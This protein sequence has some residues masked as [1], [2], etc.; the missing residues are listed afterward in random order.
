M[1]SSQ[2][3]GCGGADATAVRD[4]MCTR[5]RKLGNDILAI[6]RSAIQ[7]VDELDAVYE[8][9]HQRKRQ[10][11][12]IRLTPQSSVKGKRTHTFKPP[13]QDTAPRAQP[14]PSLP[15]QPALGE[16][17]GVAGPAAPS[18][19]SPPEAAPAA[20]SGSKV[21]TSHKLSG[22]LKAA[23]AS[24]T[25]VRGAQPPANEKHQQ[26][27]DSRNCKRLIPAT[28]LRRK[29]QK[30]SNRSTPTLSDH[31]VL[32]RVSSSDSADVGK[33]GA[34]FQTVS[35]ENAII[36][37][38]QA[39]EESY[40]RILAHPQTQLSRGGE[41]AREGLLYSQLR[42][43]VSADHNID[44]PANRNEAAKAASVVHGADGATIGCNAEYTEDTAFDGA[45]LSA[46]PCVESFELPEGIEYE[47]EALC[48]P[49]EAN[50]TS[51]ADHET[52]LQS[53]SQLASSY[54]CVVYVHQSTRIG[55]QSSRCGSSR[56]GTLR[57]RLTPHLGSPGCASAS[58]TAKEE[59]EELRMVNSYVSAMYAVAGTGGGGSGNNTHESSAHESL[60][61][62][63]ND[64]PTLMT[65]AADTARH[66]WTNVDPMVQVELRMPTHC[67]CSSVHASSVSCASTPSEGVFG[68][69]RAEESK[70]ESCEAEG[71]Q[72]EGGMRAAHQDPSAERCGQA[73][74][75]APSH[76]AADA[77]GS[78]E[79]VA[80]QIETLEGWRRD[81]RSSVEKLIRRRRKPSFAV[82]GWRGE[83]YYY[84]SPAQVSVGSLPPPPALTT[85]ADVAARGALV[86][87]GQAYS[88]VLSP[89]SNSAASAMPQTSSA[90]AHSTPQKQHITNRSG[91]GLSTF[92]HGAAHSGPTE[93]TPGRHSSSP[94]LQCPPSSSPQLSVARVCS[95]GA[96]ATTTNYDVLLHSRLSG[97]A[98]ST[99][100]TP[101]KDTAPASE[102]SDGPADDVAV[103]TK[104]GDD[105]RNLLIAANTAEGP[106]AAS[107]NSL[108]SPSS[109]I[110]SSCKHFSL[111]RRP[112]SASAGTSRRNHARHLEVVIASDY[113][114]ME[115]AFAGAARRASA[116][117]D[118]TAAEK[119]A[120]SDENC[121]SAA[122][123]SSPQCAV[124]QQRELD[125]ENH[126]RWDA[127]TRQLHGIDIHTP[128][129]LKIST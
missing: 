4:A 100:R 107:V 12:Q 69:P 127:Q 91:E 68:F 13:P 88:T 62:T 47:L 101:R 106:A 116:T 2:N 7:R 55:K 22:Q 125:E 34:S 80:A 32:K 45:T 81:R 108:T 114:S 104:A 23:P 5:I 86:G 54:Y 87:E 70:K 129:V 6:T 3:G 43:T 52:C 93:R 35:K 117:S 58:A 97:S 105:G 61:M 82:P 46:G 1:S 110:P 95:L 77:A 24:S 51:C 67:S 63:V 16:E 19:L 66:C 53:A 102:P 118:E 72:V 109:S 49:L 112:E 85:T 120:F 89:S 59:E 115:W 83:Y 36:D 20:T 99:S 27:Q 10:K 90:G 122:A 123:L 98:S 79:D 14:R 56:S 57:P 31:D 42:S 40:L 17:G 48:T 41:D 37:L 60:Q 65:N 39:A 64:A 50:A 94:W 92:M 28:S 124:Y 18:P 74:H 96:A 119:S 25:G 29:R 44:G 73:D 113:N 26:Q 8:Q 128:I 9:E 111:K 38:L 30:N 121:A 15:T 126:R 71:L 11:Q 33:A 84:S 103:E 75:S 76:A 21:R 78:N